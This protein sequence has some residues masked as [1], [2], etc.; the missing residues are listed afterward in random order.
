MAPLR[1]AGRPDPDGIVEVRWLVGSSELESW[2][3]NSLGATRTS[4]W[5]P[6]RPVPAQTSETLRLAIARMQERDGGRGERR[7]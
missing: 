6:T 1:M 2:C 4:P 5:L 7:G 3:R